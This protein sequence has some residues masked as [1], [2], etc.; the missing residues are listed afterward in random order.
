M[1]QAVPVELRSQIKANSLEIVLKEERCGP[2]ACLALSDWH[3]R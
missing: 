1:W 2:V 3:A